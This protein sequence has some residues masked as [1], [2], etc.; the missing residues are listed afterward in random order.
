MMFLFAYLG[1]L[2]DPPGWPAHLIYLTEAAF[3]M[4]ALVCALVLKRIATPWIRD[5]LAVVGGVCA[6]FGLIMPLEL[7]PFFLHASGEIML[8]TVLL[9][10]A[11]PV[12]AVLFVFLYRNF[13]LAPQNDDAED[14]LPA[15]SDAAGRLDEER[16]A[17]DLLSVIRARPGQSDANLDAAFQRLTDRIDPSPPTT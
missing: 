11:Y 4:V 1:S 9:N 3:V 17:R 2:S 13:M 6:A 16:D 8:G 7:A 15:A 12:A 14:E 10:L 5:V